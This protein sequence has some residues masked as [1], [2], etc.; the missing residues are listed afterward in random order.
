MIA[1]FGLKRRTFE[2]FGDGVR[3]L[4]GHHQAFDVTDF[5]C[6]AQISVLGATREVEACNVVMKR[7]LQ[8]PECQCQES[9]P[10]ATE[11]LFLQAR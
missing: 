4:C 6:G 1:A 7:R 10:E 3:T 8:I 9:A 5:A 11:C 2:S